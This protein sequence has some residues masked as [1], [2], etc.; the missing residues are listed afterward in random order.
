LRNRNEEFFVTVVGNKRDRDFKVKSKH[1]ASLFESK[2]L[3]VRPQRA[4]KTVE[5]KTEELNAPSPEQ[6]PRLSTTKQLAPPKETLA[7]ANHNRD[8][9]QQKPGVEVE[10]KKPGCLGIIYQGNVHEP[11]DGVEIT[12][13]SP[14]SP[15]EEIGLQAGDYLTAVEGR[16]FTRAEDLFHILSQ[17]STGTRV[18]IQYRRGRLIYETNV[19]L[20]PCTDP[21]VR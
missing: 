17:Y 12:G 11:H 3:A 21:N 7:S 6:S 8:T 5:T 20:T 14:R 1:F 10:Q 18:T 4:T 2:E 19:V 9:P 16:F 13:V 15:A